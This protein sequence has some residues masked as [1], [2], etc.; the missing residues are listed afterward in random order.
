M[1]VWNNNLMSRQNP[2]AHKLGLKQIIIIFVGILIAL[3]IVVSAF[4]NQIRSTQPKILLESDFTNPNYNN[5][6][7]NQ[8]KWGQDDNGETVKLGKKQSNAKNGYDAKESLT[9]KNVPTQWTKFHDI[10]EPNTSF[11]IRAT[12]MLVEN[13]NR[14]KETTP[15]QKET[16]PD[17]SK[18]SDY[19]FGLILKERKNGQSCDGKAERSYKLNV[20]QGL[21][22]NVTSYEIHKLLIRASRNSVSFYIGE[23]EK[24]AIGED[25]SRKL[26]KSFIL[27]NSMKNQCVG[28]FVDPKLTVAFYDLKAE[29]YLITDVESELRAEIERLSSQVIQNQIEQQQLD[30]KITTTQQK[31]E[32]DGKNTKKI[33]DKVTVADKLDSINTDLTQ[34]K[35]GTT[36]IKVKGKI[37]PD[38]TQDETDLQSIFESL[39]SLREFENLVRG[40]LNLPK[41]FKP[42]E[43]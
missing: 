13:G 26:K 41:E 16:T 39:K 42:E 28:F 24:P 34:I 36:S 30:D 9:V 21:G 18:P 25:A 14:P 35:D 3:A 20:F 31:I 37:R 4:A 40:K 29:T 27:M 23:N 11:S 22:A 10:T 7:A 19:G 2:K 33:G 32:A 5:E 1:L 15:T 43:Y 12:V 8:R 6:P 38:K 17:Q